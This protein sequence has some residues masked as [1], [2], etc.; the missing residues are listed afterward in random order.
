MVAIDGSTACGASGH[1]YY[2][3]WP[4]CCCCWFRVGGWVLGGGAGWVFY[5]DAKGACCGWATFP[6]LAA[7]KTAML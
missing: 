6:V 4:V 7:N 3:A 5:I 1:C 2:E